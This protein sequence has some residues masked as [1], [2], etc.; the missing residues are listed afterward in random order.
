MK[1]SFLLIPLAALAFVACTSETTEYV[2]EPQTAKEIAFVPVAQ[3]ATRGQYSILGTAFPTDNTME[4]KAYQSSP[5]GSAYFDKCTFRYGTITW[6]GSQYWPLSAAT[7]NFFAVS[8]Y[9]V[10]ASHITIADALASATVAYTSA[11]SYSSTTQSD[12]M[13]AFGRGSVTQTGNTLTYNSGNPVSLEFKHALALV[14]FEVKGNSATEEAAIK[15]NSITLNGAT[16]TGTL[17]LTNTGAANSSGDVTTTV[18][19]A[20]DGATAAVAVPGITSP[21]DITTSYARIGNGLMIIPETGFT[22]FTINYSM[23]GNSYN[24]TYTPSPAVNT[25][26]AAKKYTYQINFKLTEI[27]I[28]PSITD[29]TNADNFPKTIT[30]QE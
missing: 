25:T 21:T 27:E 16:Y 5:S 29:W 17:T 24:Y 18:S 11:N 15:V 20:A 22:S 9:N 7:L 14:D 6:K 19:W 13:Y 8:G 2:G 4:V 1:T 3:K 28:S 30:I 26:V 23:N 12:I 10:T